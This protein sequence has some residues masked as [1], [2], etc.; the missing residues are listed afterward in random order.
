MTTS[1]P[2][3]VRGEMDELWFG[4]ADKALKKNQNTLAILPMS[5]LLGEQGYLERL[6]MRGYEILAPEVG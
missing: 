3:D 1:I 6:R 4:A 5:A 2:A